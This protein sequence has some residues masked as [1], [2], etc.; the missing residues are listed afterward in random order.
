M[1]RSSTHHTTTKS[2]RQRQRRVWIV[3]VRFSD[4]GVW[5]PTVGVGL[6]RTDGRKSLREWRENNPCDQF[7]LSAYA[8]EP[9]P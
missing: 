4:V 9:T 3:E 1:P 7:R 8:K 6:N 5:E 2:K